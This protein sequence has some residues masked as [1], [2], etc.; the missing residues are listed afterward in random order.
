MND[1]PI[2]W[3][4]IIQTL[5]F[6]KPTNSM[7]QGSS[8]VNSHSLK[9]HV[10][11]VSCHKIKYNMNCCYYYNK[12]Q[13]F[14]QTRKTMKCFNSYL[15]EET[16]LYTNSRKQ[17]QQIWQHEGGV[18]ISG[19]V[20]TVDLWAEWLIN[21]PEQSFLTSWQLL[22]CSRII[23][24]FMKPKIPLL[25]SLHAVSGYYSEPLHHTF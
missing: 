21:H 18:T 12:T 24:A 7:E 2:Y 4:P 17:E 23:P 5:K 1:H 6:P 25:G 22:S 11:Y 10:S 16:L 15:L 3:S 9:K 8:E 20:S 13:T 19:T 14:I